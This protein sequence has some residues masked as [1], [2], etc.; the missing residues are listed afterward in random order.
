M[1]MMNTTALT[2]LNSTL[3][4]GKEKKKKSFC[5]ENEIAEIRDA[6]FLNTYDTTLKKARG[7]GEAILVVWSIVYLAIAA[8]EFTFLGRKIFLQNMALCPSRVFFLI[9]W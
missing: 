2:L 1:K 8:R 5:G 6:C 4:G 7:I 3:A 9:G